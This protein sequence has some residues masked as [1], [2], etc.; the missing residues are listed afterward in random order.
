MALQFRRGT[1]AERNAAGFIPEQGEPVY[2]IDTKRLYIGDGN[3]AGGNP[4]G[5]NNDLSDL[6]DV[7][8]ISEIDIP[9]Q[10]VLVSDGT[11]FII[12]KAP[13]GLTTGDSIYVYSSTN[14]EVNGV[15][16]VIV[17]GVTAISFSGQFTSFPLTTDTGAIKY[18]PQDGAILAYSQDTGRWGEQSYVY[19]LS[20]LGDAR[21]SNPQE[22]DIIQYTEI[23]IGEIRDSENQVVES[24]VEEPESITEGLTWTQTG[25]ITRF[26]NK[27]FEISV[28]NLND[29]LYNSGGPSNNQILVYSDILDA[30]TNRS[31]VDELDDLEDVN[32]QL[33]SQYFTDTG[34]LISGS[35]SE[36]DSVTITI[37]DTP[38]TYVVTSTDLAEA[39]SEANAANSSDFDFY[40]NNKIAGRIAG[41]IN[42]DLELGV[43]ASNDE[44]LVILTAD[45]EGEE[46]YFDF[47]T[48]DD[49]QNDQLFPGASRVEPS[50][51]QLLTYDGEFWTNK[52]FSFN[53]INI[54]SLSDVYIGNAQDGQILQYDAS[55]SSWKNVE[56]FI[57]LSQ[58]SD[59]EL[60]GVENGAALVYNDE[61]EIF[62]ARQ[63][64]LNDLIDVEDPSFT[65]FIPDGAILAYSEA[66]QKWTPQQ[67]STLASRN[68]VIFNT[69][70]LE[71]LEVTTLEI[72]AF[73]GYALFK[74]QVSAI[75]TVTL[76]VS[77]FERAADL[78]R[79]EDQAPFPGQGIFA[80]LTPPDLT[81]RRIAPVIYGYN[82]DNPISRTT[83][84]KVRNRSGFFQNN[85]EVKLTI[86]QI[87]DDPVN[88]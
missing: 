20:D 80:E 78:A 56:N 19:K 61:T 76:Y 29:V 64:I 6:Q 2:T 42:D 33:P 58:F 1:E 28:N 52:E 85:I 59:V 43:T 46:F 25:S 3:T 48:F 35:Y 75:C 55:Q 26:V 62:E 31:Y 74:I 5:F 63:F 17:T 7:E 27:P 65:Q 68:E 54:N 11:C 34:V 66:E 15:Q 18:E 87:E 37:N 49:N 22:E 51:D 67:F 86:L 32:L 45:V 53:N 9:I 10:S 16:S 47:S 38:F 82:D 79:E 81:Y 21:I 60:S 24:G 12:T 41:L 40:I 70:P 84:V 13:H 77:A 69:G 39:E 36:L 8:L 88:F 72:E 14:P 71:N 4:V 44:N 30:W 83:Y 57:T 50:L 23:P 73:T